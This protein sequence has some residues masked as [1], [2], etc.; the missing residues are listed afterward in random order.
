MALNIKDDETE[1]L[2]SEI[3]GWTGESKTGAIRTALRERR[4]RLILQRKSVD[5]QRLLRDVLER[6]IWPRVPADMIGRGPTRE[7]QD[8]ILGYGPAGT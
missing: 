6:E 2:A 3:S 8:E 4:E 1:R 5:R 7:E